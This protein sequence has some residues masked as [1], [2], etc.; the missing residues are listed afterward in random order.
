MSITVWLCVRVAADHFIL[1]AS[2]NVV[3]EAV[4]VSVVLLQ[5]LLRSAVEV[6]VQ[7]VVS[8]EKLNK[9]LQ[10]MSPMTASQRDVRARASNQ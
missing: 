5:D 10:Q 1:S 7:K 3:D 6:E 8:E 9:R 4:S 2:E